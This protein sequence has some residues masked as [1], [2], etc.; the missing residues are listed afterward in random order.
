M[1]AKEARIKLRGLR[2]SR[3][4]RKL[5]INALADKAGVS[6]HATYWADHGK[7][8]LKEMATR[9]ASAL[10]IKLVSLQS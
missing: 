4:A 6:R 9:L 8:I 2:R 5:S 3:R 1:A 10:G 7:P